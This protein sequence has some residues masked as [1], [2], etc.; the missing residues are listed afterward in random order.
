MLRSLIAVSFLRS[1]SKGNSKLKE[2]RSQLSF[3]IFEIASKYRHKGPP[4]RRMPP[5]GE[6]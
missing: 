4:A 3:Y 1:S 6:K 2:S 5:P